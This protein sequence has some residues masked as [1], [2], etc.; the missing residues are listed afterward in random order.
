MSTGPCRPFGR[1]RRRF[2]A[3]AGAVG[4]ATVAGCVG[5]LLDSTA[6]PERIEPEEPDG[7]GSPGEFYTYV[8]RNG[9]EVTSLV[10]EGSDLRLTYVSNA[11]DEEESLEEIATIATVYHKIVVDGGTDLE[12]LYAEV[13]NP[14]D[15][16]ARGWGAKTEWFEQANAGEMNEVTLWN[17]IQNSRVYETDVEA[18]QGS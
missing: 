9:V 2:L 4:T 18:I 13:A 15:E 17:S 6:S 16:Q 8:E 11:T 5:T 14:Y 10:R 1:S 3:A 7:D 12:M